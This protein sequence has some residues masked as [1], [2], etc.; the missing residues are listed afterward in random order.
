MTSATKTRSNRPPTFDR[1]RSR[2]KAATA[3]V[4]IPLDPHAAEEHARAEQKVGNLK[5]RLEA[6]RDDSPM[7]ERTET[8]LDEA[9]AEL[10]AARETLE[11]SAAR[12]VFK[13]L[14]GKEYD[15]LKKDHPPTDEQLA[16]W[17]KEVGNGRPAVNFD[18]F[19]AALVS[20]CLI[21][22][23][24]EEVEWTPAQ[25]QVLFD[26]PDWNANEI[27][28][29]IGTAQAVNESSRVVDLGKGRGRTQ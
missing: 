11:E 20:A 18:T 7:R 28:R 3:H 25:V 29:L 23:D 5:L 22:V 8:E 19:Y 16:T 21:D 9:Q 4:D 6:L 27:G 12:F 13:A 15:D 2:K 10:D 1:L 26:D 17:K 14:G 24:G